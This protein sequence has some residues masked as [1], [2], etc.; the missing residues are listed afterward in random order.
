MFSS[1]KRLDLGLRENAGHE[2]AG[3]ENEGMKMQDMKIQ[4]R[5]MKDR[6]NTT[7]HTSSSRGK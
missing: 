2:N 4:D 3:C 1:L 7:Q 6:C 5:K